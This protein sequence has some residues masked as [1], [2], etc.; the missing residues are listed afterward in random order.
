MP[1][2]LSAA[3]LSTYL[4]ECRELVLDEIRDIVPSDTRNA[5]QLYELMLEYP[6]RQ[7]KALR[8]ALCVAACRA[9]GGRLQSVVRS[10]AVLELYH[11]AFLIHDDVEDNSEMRRRGETLHRMHGVPIAIN[12]GDGMLALALAPLLDNTRLLGLGKALRI[13]QAVSEMAR[14]S[15][16]GQAEELAWIREGRFDV[17]DRDYFRMV[18]QKSAW[19]TF[20]TPVTIGAIAAG[21]DP[22]RVRALRGFAIL[23]GVAFQIQDDILNLEGEV[24]EYGKEIAGDLWEGKHTLILLNMMRRATALEREKAQR[25]LRKPRPGDSRA[26]DDRIQSL[27][28]DLVEK[29]DLSPEGEGV[30][31][32]ALSRSGAAGAEPKTLED[33]AFLRDLVDRTGSVEYAR[34]AALARARRAGRILRSCHEFVPPSVHRDFLEGL[35][36]FVVERRH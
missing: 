3:E 34:R 4:E 16:E 13:V 24:R 5:G 30:L 23:L 25:I 9:L 21:A 7:A 18:Y 20:L 12:V 28:R 26:G 27:M 36:G 15:A 19:Y 10:A 31:L 6:L 32:R 35:V 2:A 17:A 22:G 14:V 8:P 11:N 33:V 29:G 1:G